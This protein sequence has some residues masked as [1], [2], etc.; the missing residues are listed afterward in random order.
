[1]RSMQAVS[2]VGAV[3]Q[4]ARFVLGR[5]AEERENV[6]TWLKYV[7]HSLVQE[8]LARGW[9]ISDTLAGTPHGVHAVLM[10]FCGE[11]EPE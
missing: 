7:I 5:L 8:H 11:G 4:L 10:V 9:K 6:T 1:M 2:A 3:V